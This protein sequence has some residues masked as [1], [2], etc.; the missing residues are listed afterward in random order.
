[1][2]KRNDELEGEWMCNDPYVY[3]DLNNN[4]II[5]EKN[6]EYLDYGFYYGD[7]IYFSVGT[8]DNDGA[9]D[10][11]FEGVFYRKYDK[12]R[13]YSYNG[14]INCWLDYHSRV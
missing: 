13:I 6:G 10:I 1:M 9:V 2:L 11:I 4:R 3:L 12:L 14:D 7:E 8:P 5:Y